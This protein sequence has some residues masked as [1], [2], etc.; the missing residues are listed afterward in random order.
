MK[1]NCRRSCFHRTFVCRL[2]AR[3]LRFVA[4]YMCSILK[5]EDGRGLLD[6]C[7]GC[8]VLDMTDSVLRT[9]CWRLFY[10]HWSDMTAADT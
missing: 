3:L 6:S 10:G 9:R 5:P 7:A 4:F 8:N 2:V 1:L